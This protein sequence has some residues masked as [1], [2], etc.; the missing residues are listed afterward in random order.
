MVVI[1]QK[2][3]NLSTLSLLPLF[4]CFCFLFFFNFDLNFGLMSLC[5]WRTNGSSWYHSW[6]LATEVMLEIYVT[7]IKASDGWLRKNGDSQSWLRRRRRVE[8]DGYSSK[9]HFTTKG[10]TFSLLFFSFLHFTSFIFL[11]WLPFSSKRF[12]LL[13]FCS[14]L[15]EFNHLAMEVPS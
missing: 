10:S 2:R 5:W 1:L 4:F 11:F 12:F 14:S 13:A 3:L 6:W 15:K 9:V 7:T 8:V